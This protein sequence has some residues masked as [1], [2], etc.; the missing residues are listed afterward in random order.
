[1]T[2]IRKLA[3]L[4]LFI[5]IWAAVPGQGFGETG[6]QPRKEPEVIKEKDKPKQ[7]GKDQGNERRPKEEPKK[8]D[9]KKKPDF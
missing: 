4:V 6:Q 8:K 5:S 7:G 9:E 1:M 3:I 2:G